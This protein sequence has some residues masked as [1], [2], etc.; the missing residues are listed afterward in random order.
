MRLATPDYAPERE[1]WAAWEASPVRFPGRT[2]VT[3]VDVDC[4]S[5]RQVRFIDRLSD[6]RGPADPPSNPGRPRLT[7]NRRRSDRNDPQET[8]GETADSSHNFS[9][10]TA[11][12]KHWTLKHR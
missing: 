11:T 12:L 2:Q 3:R 10:F 6:Q 4:L 5:A 1:A 8:R 9:T 7:G